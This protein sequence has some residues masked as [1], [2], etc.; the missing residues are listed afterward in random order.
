[1]IMF[2]SVLASRAVVTPHGYSASVV[3]LVGR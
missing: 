3:E 2:L 1:M